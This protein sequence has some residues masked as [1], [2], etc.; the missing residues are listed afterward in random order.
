[1]IGV[2][3]IDLD[4]PNYSLSFADDCRLITHDIR[5]WVLPKGNALWAIV[6]EPSA[7]APRVVADVVSRGLSPN[8][9]KPDLGG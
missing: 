5:N 6:T 2:R 7:I 8:D 4:G 1:M 3:V 9:T